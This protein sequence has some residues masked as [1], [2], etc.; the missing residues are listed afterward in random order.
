M[1]PVL[2]IKN[3]KV[4]LFDK[5]GKI[6]GLI[7]RGFDLHL[8][9]GEKVALVGESGCGKSISAL[10]VINLFPSDKIKTID[11]SIL[12]NEKNLVDLDPNA[13]GGIRGKEISIIF[14]DPMAALNPIMTVGEQ[15]MESIR[16]N[17]KNMSAADSFLE[18]MR[19]F[20]E[21]GLPDGERIF[22]QFPHQLS[23]GMCQRICIAMALA[24]SPKL[25]IADEPTT[26][27]DVTVQSQIIQLLSKEISN[28][29]FPLL[30]I[31]HNVRLVD[32]FCER[33]A[34]VYGGQVVEEGKTSDVLSSP[35]HP[36]TEQLL[37]SVPKIGEKKKNLNILTGKVPDPSDDITGCVF[38]FRCT[39]SKPDC[40]LNPPLLLKTQ[41]ERRVRCFYPL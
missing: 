26:A 39:R 31:T 1:P 8:N 7:L 9:V 15:V 19:L 20:R 29:K 21:M 23:G 18:V 41:E 32:G 37:S 13:W 25:L 3:L 10:A 24:S 14:Q 2:E 12:L 6:H 16:A 5:A 33:V 22:K 27:L 34:V 11:G 30:F 28:L 35:K 17:R 38:A 4:G 40:F 36:Y